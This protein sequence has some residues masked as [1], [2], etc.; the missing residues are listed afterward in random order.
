MEHRSV[1]RGIVAAAA[2]ARVE[3]LKRIY[4]GMPMGTRR[5][6]ESIAE[7]GPQPKPA[8]RQMWAL[9]DYHAFAKATVWELGPILV[10][11]AG[12]GPGQ[13]VLDVAAGTGNTAIRAAQAGAEVVASDLTPENFDAGRREARAVGVEVEWTEADAE[14]LPFEDDSFDAVVSSLGAIFAPDHEA[15]ADEMLRVCKPGGTVGMINFRPTGL[16]ADFFDVLGRYAPPLPPNARPPLLWGDEH[17]VRQLFGDRVESLTMTPHTYTER[18]AGGAAAYRA[19]FEKT[20]GP[21]IGIRASLADQ[22]DRLDALDRD[23]AAYTETQNRGRPG[24]PA[25]YPYD[26]LIVIARKRR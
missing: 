16:A 19:L 23:F 15:V 7:R 26:V 24:G 14:A 21:L 6:A 9:G 10:R 17:Y 12:I 20:F 1:E 13:R 25:E 22:S 4:G 18:S 11:A 5:P 8:A 3:E 2:L